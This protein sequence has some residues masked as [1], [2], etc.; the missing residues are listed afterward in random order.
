[1]T[2][3]RMTMMSARAVVEIGLRASLRG[4]PSV[5]PGLANKLAVHSLRFVPR[6]L[7]AAIAPLTMNAGGANA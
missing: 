6:R 1:M 2:T 7:Q 3:I 5:I 4:R